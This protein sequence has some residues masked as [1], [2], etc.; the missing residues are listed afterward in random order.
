LIPESNSE[1]KKVDKTPGLMY[2]DK[3]L[4]KASF[5]R[6]E[7]IEILKLLRGI[8]RKLQKKIE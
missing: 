8:Q 4:G 1:K 7:V 6:E 2:K 3:E 5:C